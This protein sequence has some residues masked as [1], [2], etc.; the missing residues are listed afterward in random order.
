[1]FSE[2]IPDQR[3][4]PLRL[5]GDP[6]TPPPSPPVKP[7]H[8]E[9][10]DMH[11]SEGEGF[12]ESHPVYAAE[13][14][15]DDGGD[16]ETARPRQ[17]RTLGPAAAPEELLQAAAEAAAAMK[18][19]GLFDDVLEGLSAEVVGPA[20]PA[21]LVEQL[22][23]ASTDVREKQVKRIMSLTAGSQDAGAV[24][25]E[26]AWCDTMMHGATPWMYLPLGDVFGRDDSSCMR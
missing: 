21:E 3:S 7:T 25:L 1:M 17:G 26:H 16:P 18:R 23:G 14:S 4:K 19:E 2:A 20:P 6:A 22:T 24:V 9:A 5:P 8:T 13:D 11:E 10:V 12:L 15:P